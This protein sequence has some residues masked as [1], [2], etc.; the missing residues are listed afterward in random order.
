MLL[1]ELL[2]KGVQRRHFG[3]ALLGLFMQARILDEHR[4]LPGQDLQ[5]PLIVHRKS[6]EGR[7]FDIHHADQAIGHEQRHGQFRTGGR[8]SRQIAGVLLHIAHQRRLP[9]L[10]HPSHQSLS[11]LDVYTG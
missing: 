1:V 2:G 4:Q 10:C 11:Q 7:A 9:H 8:I 3:Q 6:I 5:Q